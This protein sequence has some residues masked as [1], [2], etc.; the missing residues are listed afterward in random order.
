MEQAKLEPITDAE[1]EVFLRG[2]IEEGDLTKP[3]PKS[4]LVR[5]TAILPIGLAEQMLWIVKADRSLY[6]SLD[7]LVLESLRRNV[8]RNRPEEV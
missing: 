6:D 7:D 8:L 3:K 4:D 2:L 5:L 1:Y